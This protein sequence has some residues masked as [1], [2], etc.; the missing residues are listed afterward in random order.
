M[1]SVI[2][3]KKRQLN[4]ITS[5]GFFFFLHQEVNFKKKIKLKDNVA[6]R[7]IEKKHQLSF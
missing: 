4:N 7:K 5:R 1:N 2:K 3:Y 6:T